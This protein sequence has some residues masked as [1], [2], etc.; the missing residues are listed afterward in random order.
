M[1]AYSMAGVSGVQGAPTPGTEAVLG[2]DS[3][4][5]VQAPLDIML[6][7]FYRAKRTAGLLPAAKRLSWL[8]MRDSEERAECVARFRESTAT[9][10][11]VVKEVFVARDAHWIPTIQATVPSAVGG[12]PVQPDKGPQATNQFQ[13]GKPING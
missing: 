4:R 3:A 6:A 13:L 8:T 2:A 9:L 12:T 11:Q 7:Y 1:I 10:G 5:F